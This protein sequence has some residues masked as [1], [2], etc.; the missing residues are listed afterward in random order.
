MIST[1]NATFGWGAA[2]DTKPQTFTKLTRI[3]SVGSINLEPEQ[4]DASALED[5]VEQMIDGRSS[6]GGSVTV[7]VNVTNETITEWEAVFTASDAARATGGLW[8]EVYSPY[9]TKAFFFKGTTPTKYSMPE[10]SQNSLLTV[11][12]PITISEYVGLDT[13]VVP[14]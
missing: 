8:F 1:L 11:D 7:T 10:W 2:G 6:T 13:A 3:N 12:I 5:D 9:L 14:A 4:I